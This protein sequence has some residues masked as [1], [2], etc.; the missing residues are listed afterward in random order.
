MLAQISGAQW[1]PY[2]VVYSIQVTCYVHR[3]YGIQVVQEKTTDHDTLLSNLAERN[4]AASSQSHVVGRA[5]WTPNGRLTHL[6]NILP[7]VIANPWLFY[8]RSEIGLSTRAG[9]DPC[10]SRLQVHQ[11][12]AQRAVSNKH[13]NNK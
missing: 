6:K 1:H 11:M 7:H 9:T 13:A 12:P 10:H 2:T 5:K 4:K 8:L 3:D